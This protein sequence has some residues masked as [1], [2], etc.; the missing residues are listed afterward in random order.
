MLRVLKAKVAP[1][2]NRA[3]CMVCDQLLIT[4]I[5]RVQLKNVA[6]HGNKGII[7]TAYGDT[8]GVQVIFA[9]KLLH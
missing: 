1:N 6:V 8:G 5:F 9:A 7:Y 3:L 4:S 2:K